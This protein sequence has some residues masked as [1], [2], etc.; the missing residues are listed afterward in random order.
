MVKSWKE[1]EG[2]AKPGIMGAVG[3]ENAIMD[4][5]MELLSLRNSFTKQILYQRLTSEN[6]EFFQER[7]AIHQFEGRCTRENAEWEALR[8][9]VLGKLVHIDK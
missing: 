6:R 8:E 9:V 7:A 1:L 5:T 3:H 2:N 4:D